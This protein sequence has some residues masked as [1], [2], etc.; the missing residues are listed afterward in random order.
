MRYR[1]PWLILV[2]IV[3]TAG[4]Y[5]FYW[6]WKV[7]RELRD[8]FQMAVGPFLSLL[9]V[10]IGWVLVFPPFVAWWRLQGRIAEAQRRRGIDPPSIV[11][12]V[13]FILFLMFLVGPIYAIAEWNDMWW[14]GWIL[15]LTSAFGPIYDQAE[16]NK[17]WRG[18]R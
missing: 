12:P 17:A 6:I 3:L 5:W 15:F 13:G 8:A 18:R 7:N 1:R 11:K 16:L 9:A 4:L 10:T 14:V 2:W